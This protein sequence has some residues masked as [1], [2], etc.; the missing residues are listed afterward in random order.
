M[1]SEI[2]GT[3]QLLQ[4]L[5]MMETQYKTS[6]VINPGEMPNNIIN[7]GTKNTTDSGPR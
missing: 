7:N 1:H 3:Q 4:M 2:Q 6:N 5:T